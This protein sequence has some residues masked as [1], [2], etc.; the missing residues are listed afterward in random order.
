[1]LQLA[2]ERGLEI[3]G[4]AARNISLE[5]QLKHTEIPWKGIIG[6]RNVLAHEYGAIRPDL[7]WEVVSIDLPD[8]VSKLELLV[9][10]KPQEDDE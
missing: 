6:Q 2:I 4:E 8:L 10:K 3:I 7:I 5:F 9:P 1:M